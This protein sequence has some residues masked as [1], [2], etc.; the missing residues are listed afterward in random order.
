MNMKKW[1]ADVIAAERKK[2]MPVLSFPCVTLMGINVRELISSAENQ[3]RGMKL[4]ADKVDTLASVSMMDLSVEAEAFGSEIKFEDF[5]V[6][7]VRGAIV[8]ANAPPVK[9][10]SFFASLRTFH[11]SASTVTVCP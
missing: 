5:E 1:T 6:P 9:R 4:V 7:A 8:M 2:P 3:A 10:L 11:V